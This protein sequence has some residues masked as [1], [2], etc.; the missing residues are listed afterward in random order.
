METSNRNIIAHFGPLEAADRSIGRDGMETFAPIPSTAGPTHQYMD[1]WAAN[2]EPTAAATAEDLIEGPELDFALAEARELNKEM[3]GKIDPEPTAENSDVDELFLRW[4]AEFPKHDRKSASPEEISWEDYLRANPDYEMTAS[5]E[6]ELLQSDSKYGTDREPT[7]EEIEET[8]I[9]EHECAL[10]GW[11][12]PIDLKEVEEHDTY[13]DDWYKRLPANMVERILIDTCHTNADRLNR[14]VTMFKKGNEIALQYLFH[15]VVSGPE[16]GS[17]IDVDAL[18]EIA[19]KLADLPA[20]QI[21]FGTH[22]YKPL[23]QMT[24]AQ[25]TAEHAP[26]P[27]YDHI[28]MREADDAQFDLDRSVPQEIARGRTNP[29]D[30]FSP[31]QARELLKIEDVKGFYAALDNLKRQNQASDD[32]EMQ[33]QHLCH[34]YERAWDR[35]QSYRFTDEQWETFLK[36]HTDL[37]GCRKWEESA[38]KEEKVAYWESFSMR[39]EELDNIC[40]ELSYLNIQIEQLVAKLNKTDV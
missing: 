1:I 21:C 13:T 6:L 5:E 39:D 26:L 20:N 40:A 14:L 34:Q 2:L 35:L 8:L 23:V 16:A 36:D 33:C 38:S 32:L 4:T 9:S 27:M 12:Q 31:E 29:T 25:W 24:Q 15:E 19:Q 37:E 3:Q 28:G 11:Y 17:D 18:L 10:E 22:G 7:A 30:P